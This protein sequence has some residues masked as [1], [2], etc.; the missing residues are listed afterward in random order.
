MLT[1]PRFFLCS[2][3]GNQL[4]GLDHRGRGTY[5][6]EGINAIAE[7][8]KLNGS[9]TSLDISSNN[10]CGLDWRGDGTYTAEGIMA[11]AE[12][13][14]VNGSLTSLNVSHN[15]IGAEGAEAIAEALKCNGSL[16]EVR[17]ASAHM[18]PSDLTSRCVTHS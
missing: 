14:K 16:K 13:L 7:A 4:C 5:T 10:L 8:L 11:I 12:A 9:L 6:A 15:M 2:L 1:F 3:A 17:S 18:R